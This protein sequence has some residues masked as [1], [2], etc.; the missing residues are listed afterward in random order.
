MKPMTKN[1][2]VLTQRCQ[3]SLDPLRMLNHSDHY[4]KVQQEA[5]EAS[6]VNQRGRTEPGHSTG[7]CCAATTRP[8]QHL[9]DR[10]VECL[11]VILVTFPNENGKFLTFASEHRI[12]RSPN[13]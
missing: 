7:N 3:D 10:R 8:G 4:R 5:Q 9:D 11:M 2:P 13:S 12:N 1:T 6:S